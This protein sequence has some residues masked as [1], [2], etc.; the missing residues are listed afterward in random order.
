LIDNSS[1]STSQ[2]A[3][4]VLAR[5]AYGN[6]QA[7]KPCTGVMLIDDVL[8]TLPRDEADEVLENFLFAPPVVGRTRLVVMSQPS[9]H[10]LQHFDRVLMLQHGRVI[11]NGLPNEVASKMGQCIRQSFRASEPAQI[12]A[13]ETQCAEAGKSTGKAILREASH[14]PHP[15]AEDVPEALPCG[16][17]SLLG[18]K[19]LADVQSEKDSNAEGGAL[20]ARAR[21]EDNSNWHALHTWIQAGGWYNLSLAML[22]LFLQR[23]AQLWQMLTL[24]WWGDSAMVPGCNH[25]AFAAS[26]LFI[27][28]LNCKLVVAAEWASS[29][30]GRSASEAFHDKAWLTATQAPWSC[31]ATTRDEA[32]AQMSVQL[33]QVDTAVVSLLLTGCRSAIGTILQQAYILSI[34]P[35]WVSF[36]VLLPLYIC[37]IWFG[38]LHHRAAMA[39]ITRS[40]YD[41]SRA[42]Y[43]LD[44][45]V[46]EHVSVRTNGASPMLLSKYAG[47][48]NCASIGSFVLPAACKSWVCLRATFCLS[49]SATACALHV[50]LSD[51]GQHAGVG[52]LGLVVSLLFSFLTDF[53]ASCE[54]LIQGGSAL[55]ALRSVLDYSKSCPVES[56]PENRGCCLTGRVKIDCQDLLPLLLQSSSSADPIVAGLDDLPILC[57][58]Q[59]G[60]ALACA[61]RRRLKELAPTSVAFGGFDGSSRTRNE[62][63]ASE[64]FMIVAVNNSF[65]DAQAMAAE[66]VGASGR[67]NSS[68]ILE[69]RHKDCSLGASVQAHDL[70]TGHGSM[71]PAVLKG[72]S[73]NVQ[74]AGR[75]AVIGAPSSGKST[76]LACLAGMLK[77]RA[78]QVLVA[79]A[80]RSQKEL[81]SM[82]GFVSQ[83]PTIFEGTWRENIDLLGRFSDDEIWIALQAVGL[84]DYVS[85]RP[86]GLGASLAQDGQNL[87]SG[88]KQLLS[89]A[90]MVLLRPPLLFLDDCTAVLDHHACQTVQVMLASCFYRSTVIA[91]MASKDSAIALGFMDFL[92]LS[93][94]L[95]G[96]S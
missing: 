37:V 45:T 27:V 18:K 41:M 47:F 39:L 30:F 68:V 86:V 22:L 49:V 3:K 79:G 77:P 58:S 93:S 75:L 91:S 72:L 59:G 20:L 44:Q 36:A 42:E 55:A 74:A 15:D 34:A 89:L 71:G 80:R 96:P 6:V 83:E 76:L 26:L 73:L 88:Q 81:R 92:H 52:T 84:A 95:E 50:L 46:P 4:L 54:L 82:A 64:Q 29:R 60:C 31:P 61:G 2:R 51:A 12:C 5:T 9:E 14:L 85:H 78:G 57:S 8:G 19:L 16:P 69:L 25:R 48:M 21:K 23:L 90:R 24:A 53:E 43:L 70:Y 1:L 32:L 7:G 87:S 35:V 66:L 33:A 38:F 65:F 63:D 94:S 17:L 62:E 40:K 56:R 11:A 10:V 13:S 28:M 67:T